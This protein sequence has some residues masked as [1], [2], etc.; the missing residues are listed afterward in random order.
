MLMLSRTA[1]RS[2]TFECNMAQRPK[3][4]VQLSVLSTITRF[5][6]SQQS[7]KLHVQGKS[8]FGRCEVGYAVKATLH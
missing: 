8:Y 2:L 1:R 6:K 7:I 5:T 3:H 4:K